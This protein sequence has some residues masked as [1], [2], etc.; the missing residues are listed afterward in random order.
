M[1]GGHL[2]FHLDQLLSAG[3]IA[4]NGRKGDYVITSRG[5]EVIKKLMTL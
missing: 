4:Q 3:L 5:V 1:R 2:T